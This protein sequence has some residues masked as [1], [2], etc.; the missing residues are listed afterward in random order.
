VRIIHARGRSPA[1][2]AALLIMCRTSRLLRERNNH[3]AAA[4]LAGL[5]MML[6]RAAARLM[7]VTVV[8]CKWTR[9]LRFLTSGLT[10]FHLVWVNSGYSGID[11]HDSRLLLEDADFGSLSCGASTRLKARSGGLAER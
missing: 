10:P 3:L 7:I 4:M 9:E 2:P 6:A 11:M 8:G 5:P 1:L